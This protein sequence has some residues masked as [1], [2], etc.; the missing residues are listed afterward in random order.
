MLLMSSGGGVTGVGSSR[1][2]SDLD[3]WQHSSMGRDMSRYLVSLGQG[4]SEMMSDYA[5]RC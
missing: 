3:A 4:H 2:S 1:P 5:D